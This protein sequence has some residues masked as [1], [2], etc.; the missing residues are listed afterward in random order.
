[1]TRVALKGI[2]SRRMRT[3]LTMFAIVLGVA[4]VAGAYT[5]TDT[6]RG[7][8]ES[9]SDAA[10]DGT[11]AVVSHRTAFDLK[12][13]GS[14]GSRPTIPASTLD[15]V[16]A[17]PGVE[18]AVGSI[19]DEARI[20]DK[21]GDVIGG[22][23]YFGIGLDPKAGELAPFQLQDGRYATAA[24]EA[25]IDAGTADKEG[26]GIGDRITVQGRGPE[27]SLEVTGIATFGDVDSI[28]TATFVLMDLPAAQAM[29][30]KQGRY[31][32]VLV[33]GDDSVRSALGSALPGQVA[34]QAA[35]DHDRFTL[36]GL[37][38]FVSFI[39]V[40]LLVFGGVAVFVGSFTIYNTLSITVAQRFRELAL[41]RALGAS[42]RQV[43]RSVLFESLLIGTVA[44][45]IGLGV[46]LLLAKGLSSVFAATGVELPETG[47]VF[48]TR[49]IIVSLAVGIV[50]TLVSGL[51]PAIR[52]TRVAPVLA[53]REG[54]EIPQGR[55]GR[56]SGWIA[57]AAALLAA[58]VLGFGL[59]APGIDATGRL[60][61]LGPGALL[62][63]IAV[64][65]ASSR[66]VPGLV[67]VLGKP[68][69]K[70]AGIAGSL[71]RRNA[72]RN[73][74]RTAATAAALMIGIALVAF[75]AVLGAGMRESTKG[76]LEDQVRADYV[77]VGQDG[78]SAIDPGAARAA[79]GVPG[80]RVSTG[81]AQDE[82]RAFGEHI[83]VDGVDERALPNV[84]GWEWKEGSD[85]SFAG[86]AN[87]GAVVT[88]RFADDHDVA[89]GDRIAVT[90]PGG[91][92]LDLR[93]VGI[94]K[95]DRFNPLGLGQV[96]ISRASFD[97]AFSAKRERLA[98]VSGD[99]VSPAALDRALAGF[100]D[101][102]LQTKSEFQTDQSA[103]V[104]QILGI[105]YVLL[106]LAVIISL[107]G[108]VNTLALSVMERTRE[109]GMLR[110]FGMTRRGVRR[111]IRHESIVTALVG[112]TLGI[113][114]GLLLAALATS[115]LSEEGLRFALP[116][117][118]LVAFTVVA[119]V[120][121]MLAAI[122]PA[123]RAARLDVVDALGYE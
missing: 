71:A 23:P 49:T 46:G 72:M 25:V 118:S 108:I 52:A 55:V 14:L 79:A 26:Y 89:T 106:G 93:V 98:F 64:A 61:L 73:P 99:G 37:D 101:V 12:N 6:M 50:V 60:A 1:M 113:A 44:S 33:A 115:A 34:V 51:S 48:A 103:W 78:W 123:R 102:K 114:V 100:P 43:L 81:L 76:A 21:D 19:T 54:A 56:R 9:L 47:T 105:F 74:G 53:M 45:V 65:A 84:F 38:E 28:G 87:G 69:E 90:A 117:G 5:L 15:E 82:G 77:L 10:Y 62:L 22:G 41:L 3:A 17:V 110:A 24:G 32:E 30:E 39:R 68:G 27:R 20:V 42:R 112:A 75:S 63:F 16:R 96:T 7:A 120:A 2:L 29:F 111:M 13:E 70:I 97:D 119:A 95:P 116:L 122:G 92:E 57:A 83:A 86:L 91:R 35:A 88:D 67:S 94:S 11:A 104:D 40:F 36:D 8:S 66:I 107:F 85:A 18:R 80:V 31:D 121:G 58:T 109:L 4:M 59:Y